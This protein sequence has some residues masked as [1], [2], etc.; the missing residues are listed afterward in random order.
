MAREDFIDIC[1]YCETCKTR[2]PNKKKHC[3]HIISDVGVVTSQCSCQW[4]SCTVSEVTLQ[5]NEPGTAFCRVVQKD[6]AA[7]RFYE[8]V[9]SAFSVAVVAASS[10]FNITIDDYERNGG[11]PSVALT[12]KTEY[13]VYCA[14]T[15]DGC[16]GCSA[17]SRA[18]A[19]KVPVHTLDTTSPAI[20]VVHVESVARDR[21]RILLRVDEGA[22]V[23]LH[24]CLGRVRL[25]DSVFICSPSCSLSLPSPRLLAA[26]RV[27]FPLP[28]LLLP[29]F[30]PLPSAA[31]SISLSS[32]I[33]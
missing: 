15:D 31:R 7:K 3:D 6:F 27:I 26:L 23:I 33:C 11:S 4:Q 10:D 19:A 21:L 25:A 17:S 2:F 12:R 13:D 30:P 5:L 32:I 22:K 24:G 9:D 29:R 14:A 18:V 28:S 8:I 16:T 20:T 1:E